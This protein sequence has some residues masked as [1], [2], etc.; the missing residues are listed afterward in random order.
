LLPVYY[1]CFPT[2]P[3]KW[4]GHK[5]TS[6]LESGS[7]RRRWRSKTEL[8]RRLIEVEESLGGDKADQEDALDPKKRRRQP[9]LMCP[10]PNDLVTMSD[11]AEEHLCT[12]QTQKREDGSFFRDPSP[13]GDNKRE[14]TE[15]AEDSQDSGVYKR[16]PDPAD[17]PIF[18]ARVTRVRRQL[19]L[20]MDQA[21]DS[22]SAERP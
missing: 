12:T 22:T 9:H 2:K 1:P 15:L 21:A 7:T 3:V 6:D 11:T 13:G 8:L 18:G 20:L 4:H 19:T 5:W 14:Q 17:R 10:D 16:R